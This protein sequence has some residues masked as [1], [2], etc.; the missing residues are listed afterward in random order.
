MARLIDKTTGEFTDAPEGEAFTEERL[1]RVLPGLL[2]LK[3]VKRDS[4]EYYKTA[5]KLLEDW[6]L[7]NP[8]QCLRNGEQGIVARWVEGGADEVLDVMNMAV[9]EPDA[10][11]ELAKAGL[12]K[13]DVTAFK[14]QREKLQAGAVAERFIY[15]KPRTGHVDVSKEQ[16]GWLRQ[17]RYERAT[18]PAAY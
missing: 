18:A 5:L 2:E 14:A 6:L 3:Y 7:D 17:N 16:A 9:A 15:S 12:L 13:L 1:V 8:G 11:L 10:L 4:A